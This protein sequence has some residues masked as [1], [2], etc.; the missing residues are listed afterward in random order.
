MWIPKWWNQ[1]WAN[2]HW[3]ER[4][5]SLSNRSIHWW[6]CW[7]RHL[8]NLFKFWL[9]WCWFIQNVLF[10]IILFDR[11]TFI[12][13]FKHFPIRVFF[14]NHLKRFLE[15]NLLRS[16]LYMSSSLRSNGS[17]FIFLVMVRHFWFDSIASAAWA[18]YLNCYD[19][20]SLKDNNWKPHFNVPSV[21]EHA[22]TLF[23]WQLWWQ[24]FPFAGEQILFVAEYHLFF[25]IKY[26]DI[27]FTHKFL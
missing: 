5:G 13:L 14:L 21:F 24:L 15:D 12:R 27:I 25:W 8:K 26:L 19:K 4:L 17:I 22:L 20:S 18:Q 10:L 23:W 1:S 3:I 9:W 6:K 11:V 16:P 7:I 2:I